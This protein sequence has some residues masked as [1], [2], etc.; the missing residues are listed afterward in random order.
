[1]NVSDCPTPD[2]AKFDT[3]GE[4]AARSVVSQKLLH[5]YL[6]QCGKWHLTMR[7]VVADHVDEDLAE[8][9]STLPDADFARHVA[10]ELRGKATPEIAAALRNSRNWGRWIIAL[11]QE[12]TATNARLAE[13]K[14]L[15]DPQ[16]KRW[17]AEVVRF[18]GLIHS[19]RLEAQTLREERRQE[20]ESRRPSKTERLRQQ[21]TNKAKYRLAKA[22]REEYVALLKEELAARGLPFDDEASDEKPA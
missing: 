19:R 12:L 9:L 18:Q 17:R 1:M 21:A 11:R 16:T 14:G 5:P 20:I 6:C 22:H 15:E 4:A 7:R 10:D 3:R 8:Q 2:K 13:K